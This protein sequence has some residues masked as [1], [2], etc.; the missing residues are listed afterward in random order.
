[1]PTPLKIPASSTRYD[2]VQLGGGLDLLTPIL[3]L[4]PGIVR[5]S[6]NYEQSI[7]GGY[8]RIAGYERFSGKPAPSL[9]AYSTLTLQVDALIVTGDTIMGDTSHATGVI[10]AINGAFYSYT[11]ASGSFLTG[12]S[13]SVSGVHKGAI[14]ALGGVLSDVNFDAAQKALAANAYRADIAAPPGSGRILGGFVLDGTVYALR[15]NANGTAAALWRSSSTGWQA[16][17]LGLQ[18]AFTAGTNDYLAGDTITQGGVSGTVQSVALETGSWGAGTAAGRLIVGNVTG[19]SFAGGAAAGNGNA[20]LSAV[21]TAI[22]LLPNGRWE[23]DLGN[24]GLG[25]RAYGADGVN[26]FAYEFDGTTLAPIDP[27]VSGI[28]PKHPLVHQD[29]LFLCFG[30]L[31]QHSGIGTPFNWTSV[32]GAAVYNCPAVINALSRQPGSQSAGA[33]SITMDD[34]TEMLYGTSAANFQKVSFEQSGGGRQ[35]GV[36]R[37]GGQTYAYGDTGVMSVAASQQFGN[38]APSSLTMNIRPFTQIRRTNCAATLV[39]REKS[40]YRVFF[41]DSYG[42]YCT[43]VNGRMLGAMPVF[44]TN[45]VSVAWA[46]QSA[47]GV[48][49]AYFGSENGMVYQLDAGTSHDGLPIEAFMTLVF[50]NQGNTRVVK[51]YR[52]VEFE[53]QGDGYASFATTYD[54][55]YGSLERAQ[56]SAPVN[57]DITL[58]SVTWDTPSMVWDEFTWDGR[59]LAPSHA[60]LAGSGENIALRIESSSDIYLPYTINS[61]IIHYSTRKAL[62]S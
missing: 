5:D 30:P 40:Q 51:R 54:V 42:L 37:L 6:V 2:L 44:F 57:V 33:M 28:P 19:G 41:K 39:N 49:V 46:G 53:V 43:I 29:H 58:S 21:P 60:E 52:G 35:Y 62:K 48:E 7:T 16:V 24:F 38:F 27:K 9:A 26:P 13:V 22:P 18:V 59:S 56:G 23:F 17:P 14:T 25:R 34:Q 8:T 36:Q 50:A 10:T 61:A 45:P 12:E 55:G 11:K 32:A 20:T 4:K 47:D 15:N 31:L 3:R 1:M